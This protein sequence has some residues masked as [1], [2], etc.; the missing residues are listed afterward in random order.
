MGVMVIQGAT[1]FTLTFIL[2][3][4]HA[5]TLDMCIIAALLIPYAAP[6]PVLP[7]P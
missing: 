2:A 6:V 1:A 4:S 7:T 5:S 3:H